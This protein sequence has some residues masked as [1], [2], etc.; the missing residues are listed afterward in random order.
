MIRASVPREV[1][2]FFRSMSAILSHETQPPP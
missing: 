1:N 2:D